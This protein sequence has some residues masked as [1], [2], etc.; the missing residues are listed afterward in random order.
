VY[1]APEVLIPII[2]A[3]AW[4]GILLIISLDSSKKV[5]N[6]ISQTNS[7]PVSAMSP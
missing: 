6:E 5:P 3:I 2:F 4:V 1:V 7:S